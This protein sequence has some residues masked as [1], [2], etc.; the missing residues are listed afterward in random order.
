M[1]KQIGILNA[2]FLENPHPDRVS[3]ETGPILS[4]NPT[5]SMSKRTH[6]HNKWVFSSRE[7]IY[8]KKPQT[9]IHV[10]FFD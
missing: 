9:T 6:I 1:E 5:T 8:I 4:G 10:S 7:C 3:R 2:V